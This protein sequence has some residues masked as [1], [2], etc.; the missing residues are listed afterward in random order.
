M[1]RE[2]KDEYIEPTKDLA[3][4][5]GVSSMNWQDIHDSYKKAIKN[6]GGASIEK[7]KHSSKI[8]DKETVADLRA[9][10]IPNEDYSDFSFR[11]EILNKKSLDDT[12]AYILNP[13]FVQDLNQICEIF[14]EV[15]LKTYK[16]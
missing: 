16:M 14:Q 12:L 4:D 13:Q 3:T 1:Q 2:R 8:L 9:V 6:P 7:I 15:Q 11:D 10:V 5:T